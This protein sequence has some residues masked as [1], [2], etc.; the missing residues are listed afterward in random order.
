M[1]TAKPRGLKRQADAD[2]FFP[3]P[4]DSTELCGVRPWAMDREFPGELWNLSGKLTGIYFQLRIS[5]CF[6]ARYDRTNDS[7]SADC[8]A[9]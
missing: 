4:G 6:V 9:G 3:I 5:L 7:L 2:I 1:S 8:F